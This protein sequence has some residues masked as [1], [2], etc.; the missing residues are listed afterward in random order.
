MAGNEEVQVDAET[1]KQQRSDVRMQINAA[2]I[3]LQCGTYQ[4]DGD[5]TLENCKKWAQVLANVDATYG[6]DAQSKTYIAKV[7]EIVD[8]LKQDEQLAKQQQKPQQLPPPPPP[9]PPSAPSMT[10]VHQVYY[11][12]DSD[13]KIPQFDGQPCHYRQFEKLFE[14]KYEQD[15]AYKAADKFLIF[16]NLIGDKGR[17]MIIDLDPDVDGLKEA[18]RRL[19]EHYDDPYRVRED[20]RKRIQRLPRITDRQQVTAL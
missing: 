13:A 4:E 20:I 5:V 6:G 2:H 10:Q 16:R 1:A 7:R 19:K 18:K 12:N 14:C 17:D 9:P 11:R 3:L 15:P 8:Q